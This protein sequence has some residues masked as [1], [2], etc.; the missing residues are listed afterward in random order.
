MK[1]DKR[2]TRCMELNASKTHFVHVSGLAQISEKY[3]SI[4]LQQMKDGTTF[5]S[6]GRQHPV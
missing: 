4:W 1:A 3:S 2:N 6:G 5:E